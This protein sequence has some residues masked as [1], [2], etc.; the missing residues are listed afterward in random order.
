MNN[1]SIPERPL[2]VTWTDDQ[3]KAIWAKGQDIL[4]AAAAGSGKT[5]VLVERI[6][7]RILSEEDRLDVDELLVVTF[8]NASAAEMRHRIGQAIEK[9]IDE[10]PHST[11]LR[12]QLSLLNRAS[13]STL[14]SFCLEV[15]RKYYYLIDIDPGFRI[16]DDTEGDLIRDEVLEELLEEEYGKKDHTDF[17]RLV[18]TFSNDR[19]DGALQEMIRKLYDFSRSHPDPDEWLRELSSMYSID[20]DTMIDDLPLIGTLKMDIRL[21]L[22][23]A[24]K[25]LERAM[26]MTK[27]PGGPAP[28]AVNFLDDLS[29]VNELID[30]QGISWNTLYDKMQNLTFT[31]LKPCR[32]DEFDKD[33]VDEA[34]KLRDQAKKMLEKLQEEFFLRRPQSF[35][36]DM[37]SMKEVIR[38]LSELVIEFGHR[39]KKVKEEKGLVDFADLEHFCLEILKEKGSDGALTPSDAALQY[40]DKFK[41]V[42][43]DEYQ[44]TNMVQESILLLIT[45][46]EESTGNRFMVGDVKQSIY[47]FRLAEPN[48]FLA[49][50]NRFLPE[51]EESGLKIDLSRNFRS[52]KEVLEGTNFLFKQIMG[53]AVGEMEYNREAELVKGAP[54]PEEKEYPIEVALIDQETGEKAAAPEEEPLSVFDEEDIE[55]SVLEARY[56]AGRVK[57]MIEGGTPVYDPKTKTE[58]PVQYKDIVILL[59]SMPWAS[60][61]MEEF[62][63]QGIPIYANLSTGYFE[64]TEVSIML[65][66]LKVIDNPYQ[67]IALA[68]V[69]RSPIV[70]LDEEGLASI[71]MHSRSGTY[72]EAMKKFAS[73][74]PERA[75]EEEAFEKIKLFSYQLDRWRT[76][77]RQGSVTELIWQLYRDTRFYDYVGGMAGGKQRQA[78][79]RA[80]YD[81]AR[82]Y[83][84]TTF[85][86]LFR[87]LRFIDRMRERGDDLGVA[88]AL[89][90]QEDVVRLMT[91]HSSKGLEF[92]IVFVAGTSKQFNL[93]DLNASYLLDKDLGF[94]SK[95][96]DPEKRISYPSLPQLAFKRK[97]RMEAIS[98]EMRVLY[99]ALTRA[100]ERLF[101]VGTVKDLEKSIE[102]WKGSMSESGWLLPDYDRAGASS[103]LDWIGPSLIRHPHCKELHGG[104]IQRPEGDE[105][106]HAHPSCWN[107]TKINK[108]ELMGEED[109][110]LEEGEDWASQVEEGKEVNLQSSLKEDVVGRLSWTYPNIQATRLRS[111]QSVSELK[112]MYEIRDESS[113]VELL[114]R[115]QK[116]VYNRPAFMQSKELS[117]AE[118]GTAMHTVMQHI[119]FTDGKPSEESVKT[120][121][122]DLVRKEILSEEQRQ[123]ISITNIVRFFDSEP[124]MRILKADRVQREVPFSM[125]VPLREL[126]ESGEEP[127]EETVLVQGVIDCIFRDESGIVLLDYKTDGIHDRY[128]KGFEEAK[129]VLETRYKIQIEL[130]TKA[131]ESIW[132]ETVSEKYLYF[133]DGGH[134]LEID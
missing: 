80:L 29:L 37:L 99:V 87:F 1:Y 43:V 95:Y 73:K 134:L 82:Q 50:Y 53:T 20:E 104:A 131:L 130:Y 79:L 60:E 103:Y 44:D 117:P 15:I 33:L 42:L 26:D 129:E 18:D 31:K 61:I 3:W 64:A 12:K 66:L 91:I 51:P 85:R 94:A 101:L 127:P 125:S 39:F 49:K 48:L 123:S 36:T 46:E 107:V 111:K 106:V 98:E 121:L 68:S 113:S 47:R 110:D 74:K 30:A 84:E 28:R 8:T 6:I 4:V 90:E 11:H 7:Q 17:F 112:R 70:G 118:K 52:R 69:L 54:Y 55:K 59:R 132:K 120:L 81:R 86:G 25:L 83:E 23:G 109:V 96:T 5:A 78:N 114:R 133:F 62:K 128:K 72:Y 124:G 2:D 63:R 105:G 75:S 119:S 65:S 116:P 45:G 89:S 115:Q 24:K 32:G 88:R 9:A 126:S 14:H 58:R 40:K 97:K 67:D 21:Q 108:A 102:K 41:E 57:A 35:L 38:T 122:E 13:I 22:D 34:K 92:P 93:M 19:S 56:M 76:I 10:D 71:R 100:K 16:A 77:A 27:L